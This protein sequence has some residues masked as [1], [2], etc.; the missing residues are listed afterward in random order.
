MKD[1]HFSKL[2]AETRKAI[3]E[4][5]SSG[6]P[7]AEQATSAAAYVAFMSD[8]DMPHLQPRVPPEAAQ[9]FLLDH[10]KGR[11]PAWALRAVKL[12]ELR[13]SARQGR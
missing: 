6:K 10:E 12:K 9:E 4:P 13:A 8:Y 5:S 2:D 1:Y 3:A 11:V 7:T